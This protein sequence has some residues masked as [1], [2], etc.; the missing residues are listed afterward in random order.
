VKLHPWLDD[1]RAVL[2]ARAPVS[3]PVGW[4]DYHRAARQAMT[5][6]AVELEGEALVLKPNVTVGE[7]YEDPDSGITTHPGFVHGLI[8][9]ALAH[10]ARREAV[11]ILEDPRNSDDDEPRHWRG[12]GYPEVRERTGAKLRSP[13]L[14]TCVT[15]TV[16]RPLCYAKIKVSK[17]AVAPNTVLFNVPKMKTHNLGITT[18]CLKNLMGVVHVLDRHFCGQAMS[19]IPEAQA[20]KGEPKRTWMDRPLHEAWQAGL[21]RR[22]IDLAQVVQPRLNVVEGVVAR[23]GTGFNRGRNRALGL[24]VAGVNR[25]AVDSVTSALMGFDPQALVYL[26]MAAEAG[27]GTNDL[28][29]L[30]IYQVE[31]GALVPCEDLDAFRARPPLQVISDIKGEVVTFD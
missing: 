19:E 13:T 21:A 23:E 17:L 22:L 20:F 16:P 18:L 11:T 10:G 9:Y 29:A 6:M 31:D 14:D 26:R 2:I 12:T 5:A 7:R 30:R 8:D 4:A 27:L 15:Q 28:A 3:E 24:C 25:V 1:P